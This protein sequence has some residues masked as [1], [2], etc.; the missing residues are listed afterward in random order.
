MIFLHTGITELQVELEKDID[1]ELI[2]T[3][4]V[5]NKDNCMQLKCFVSAGSLLKFAKDFQIISTSEMFLGFW[6]RTL[7]QAI[8]DNSQLSLYDIYDSVWRPS[9]GLCRK[10]L[11]SLVDQS[12]KLSDVDTDLQPYRDCL[13]LQLKLLYDQLAEIS[14]KSGYLYLIKQAAQ[15]V[16]E[17][18][19]LCQYKKGADTFLKLKNSLG[20]SKGD[21]QL[22]EILSEQVYYVM[23]TNIL[24]QV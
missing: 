19:N 14:Q 3:M 12:M 17:Y 5:R 8:A 13:D 7:S 9:L 11:E 18:W 6:R 20:L 1:K 23:K 24:Y 21:F 10:L 4:C 15:R 16:R 2:N 22:V